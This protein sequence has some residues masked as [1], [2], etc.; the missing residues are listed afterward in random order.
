MGPFLEHINDRLEAEREAHGPMDS[1]TKFG[2]LL[3]AVS[4]YKPHGALEAGLSLLL[5]PQLVKVARTIPDDARLLDAI[6]AAAAA[7]L[8]DVLVQLQ[9]DPGTVAIDPPACDCA[10]HPGEEHLSACPLF[11]SVEPL[12]PPEEA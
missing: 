7:Q 11:G 8:G 9:S 6:L 10:A 3:G 4:T 5:R 12:D 1:P 2:V